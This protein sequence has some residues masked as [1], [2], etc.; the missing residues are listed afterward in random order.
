MIAMIT[1]DIQFGKCM[2][3]CRISFTPRYDKITPNPRFRY[4]N[5]TIDPINKKYNARSP[6]TA[7][8]LDV[9]AIKKSFVIDR[10]AGTESTANTISVAS[11]AIN[12]NAN[13]VKIIFL[14]FFTYSLSPTYSFWK[15]R[16]LVASFTMI[17]FSILVSSFLFL[18]ILYP[19][20]RRIIAKT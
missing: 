12:T 16:N 15:E 11:T 4:F 5:L 13:G 2:N 20:Y 17:L 10:T 14:F 7:K 1:S 19:E 6:S 8:M 18:I 9:Y 3:L